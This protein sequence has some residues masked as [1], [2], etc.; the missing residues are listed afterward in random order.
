MEEITP[1]TL[2]KKVGNRKNSVFRENAAIPEKFRARLSDYF[3][4]GYDR[5]HM[6]PASDAKVSQEG[7]ENQYISL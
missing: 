1:D 5:G 7:M 4:S 3:R 6:V 2:A